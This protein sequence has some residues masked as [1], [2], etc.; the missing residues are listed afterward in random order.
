MLVPLPSALVYL[1]RTRTVGG[2][3][4]RPE[5]PTSTSIIT[6]DI[7]DADVEKDHDGE[8]DHDEEKRGLGKEK[9]RERTQPNDR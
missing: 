7:S 2:L 8:K 3:L 5:A 1:S 9:E 4:G 6:R